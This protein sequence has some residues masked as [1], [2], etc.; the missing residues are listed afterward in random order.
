MPP[1]RQKRYRKAF[2]RHNP[3]VF[4]V[5]GHNEG[6]RETVARFLERLGCKAVILHE[7]PSKGKT[8]F[9]KFTAHSEVDFAVVLLTA[10]DRGG[11]A[12]IRHRRQ[13]KRARQ[14]VILELGFFL[15]ALG[16]DKVCSLYEDEVELPSDYAGV[17]YIPLGQGEKWRALLARELESAGFEIDSKQLLMT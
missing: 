5:H 16:P 4:I 14:N 1:P 8:I 13:R 6:I 10:D 12:K 7:L 2:P 3:K 11:P 15:V 17:V 9:Q